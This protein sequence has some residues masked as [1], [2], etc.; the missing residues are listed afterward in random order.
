MRQ[1]IIRYNNIRAGLLKELDT[2]EYEFIYNEHYIQNYPD[3]F[4]SFQMPVRTASYKSKRLFPFFDGLI[5]EGWLLEIAEKTW[6]IDPRDR[7]GLLLACCRD[8][9]GA[10]GVVPIEEEAAHE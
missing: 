4:I 7:M 3:L 5:P 2:G 10:A 1:A 9:I 8:C 6:K